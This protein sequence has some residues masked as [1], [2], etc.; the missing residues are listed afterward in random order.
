MANEDLRALF[1]QWFA[2]YAD[3]ALA[4]FDGLTD[5]EYLW[6][7]TP[8]AWSVR[9]IGDETIVDWA[10]P[11]PVPAPVTTIAWR[12]VHVCSFLTEHGLR[13]VAFE[14]GIANHVAPSVIPVDAG[15]GMDAL[16]S[17]IDAWQHDLAN[18]SDARLW[19][20]MG[21]EGGAYAAEP[22]AAFVEHIHDEFVHHTAEIALLR[23]L[24]GA[25]PD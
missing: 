3:R 12:F 24:Y 23:D 7:P 2:Y 16:R 4:R 14:G 8:D 5:D 13:A 21:I 1:S 22:V 11:P 20:P 9:R 6:E 18:V 17:A 25:R 15:E 19:E 10:W